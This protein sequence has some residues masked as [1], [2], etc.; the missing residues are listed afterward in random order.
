MTVAIAFMLG[1][2]ERAIDWIGRS[3]GLGVAAEIDW[4]SALD[5]LARLELD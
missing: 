2:E 4:C 1:D 3:G 5:W